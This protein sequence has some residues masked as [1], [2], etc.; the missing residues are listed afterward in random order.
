[1]SQEDW[2]EVEG[3]PS[4][5]ETPATTIPA[6]LLT[7]T[8]PQILPLNDLT[9]ENFERLCLRYVRRRGSVVR[10]QLYG[11]KG[12]AQDGIDL[13]VRLVEPS[14]YEV[15]QSKKLE[16]LTAGDIAKATEKFVEGKWF[17]R[18]KAFRMMISHE[19]EDTKI[20]EAIEAAGMLLEKEGIE[21]E[22]L[23]A[24][25]ISLWLKDEP[26]IVD[27][28]F[29]RAVVGAFCGAEAV[30]RLESRLDAEQVA[31]YRKELRRFY[32][33]IFNRNDPGIP[34]RTRIG[35]QEISL[36]ERFVV[37]DV[38]ASLSPDIG[39]RSWRDGVYPTLKSDRNYANELRKTTLPKSASLFQRF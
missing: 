21:F 8:R 27:D 6:S 32:E 38:Y 36:R 15:Y 37:P 5:L 19:I 16:K 2:H 28:F 26:R 14:R 4:W 29:S 1:M 3:L 23:G 39:D 11:V 7:I 9:W 25:Q 33:V 24:L 18:S 30:A 10:T 17:D 35:D 13:Y 22:V 34:V 12:Q 20:A 31:R